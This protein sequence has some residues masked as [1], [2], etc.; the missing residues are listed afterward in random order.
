MSMHHLLS[1]PAH[2]VKDLLY[3]E[4]WKCCSCP[5]IRKVLIMQEVTDEWCQKIFERWCRCVCMLTAEF[6][7]VD[8]IGGYRY[9][10]DCKPETLVLLAPKPSNSRINVDFFPQGISFSLPNILIQSTTT[11]KSWMGL[12]THNS[13]SVSIRIISEHK[14]TLFSCQPRGSFSPL[15]HAESRPAGS[16]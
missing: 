6:F 12:P 15:E 3:S 13:S 10:D 14:K 7:V 16:F 4:N 11:V 1:M 9:M 5:L 8:K 2:T